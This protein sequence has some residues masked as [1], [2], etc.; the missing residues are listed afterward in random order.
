MVQKIFEALPVDHLEGS[1][2]PS[3][4][5]TSSRSPRCTLPIFLLTNDDDDDHGDRTGEGVRITLNRFLNNKRLF[6][7][8]GRRRAATSSARTHKRTRLPLLSFPLDSISFGRFKRHAFVARLPQDL[9]PHRR[10]SRS[11]PAVSFLSTSF[12][13]YFTTGSS[14]LTFPLSTLDSLRIGT[15]TAQWQ[16]HPD[17]PPLTNSVPVCERVLS[18][19]L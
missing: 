7:L 3:T 5:P 11:P 14:I 10:R 4:E 17:H 18:P 9:Y 15:Q 8:P 6:S 1:T 13:T 2:L 16:D 19:T 12:T